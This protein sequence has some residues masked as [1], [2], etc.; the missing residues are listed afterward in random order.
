M[1]G[2]PSDYVGAVLKARTQ[3]NKL[4]AD[5]L[6]ILRLEEERMVRA[7]LLDATRNPGPVTKARATSLIRSVK[8]HLG[9]YGLRMNQHTTTQIKKAIDLG[10]VGHVN[11]A[12]AVTPGLVSE[13]LFN[14]VPPQTLESLALRRGYGQSALFQTWRSTANGA[15]SSMDTWLFQQVGSGMKQATAVRGIATNL[16][17]GDSKRVSTLIQKLGQ[18]GRFRLKLPLGERQRLNALMK[19]TGPIAKTF[20]KDLKEARGLLRDARRIAV[21]EPNTAYFEADRMSAAESPLVAGVKWNLSGRHDAI[22]QVD[23]C[24]VFVSADYYKMGAG[25]FPAEV[26]PARP[27]PYCACWLESVMRPASEWGKPKPAYG[28]PTGVT[29]SKVK[30]L[31]EK[32]AKEQAKSGAKV[33]K[34]TKARVRRVRSKSNSGVGRSNVVQNGGGTIVP[35]PPKPP[36]KVITPPVDKLAG[37]S[38]L[39]TV[40]EEEWVSALSSMLHGGES[41][42]FVTK[43]GKLKASDM[44]ALPPSILKRTPVLTRLLDESGSRVKSLTQQWSKAQRKYVQNTG[45]SVETGASKAARKRAV[46]TMNRTREDIERIVAVQRDLAVR[47]GLDPE[48]YAQMPKVLTRTILELMEQAKGSPAA[49]KA[50]Q[51]ALDDVEALRQKIANLVKGRSVDQTT[52]DRHIAT[53]TKEAR[54][55]FEK[56]A[57]AKTATERN[58]Q[59]AKLTSAARRAQQRAEITPSTERAHF[60]LRK[61]PAPKGRERV[62]LVGRTGKGRFEGKYPDAVTG[63]DRVDGFIEEQGSR[64]F[65]W[66]NDHVAPYRPIAKKQPGSMQVGVKELKGKRKRAYSTGD[67]I[68]VSDQSNLATYIHEFGHQIENRFW[69]PNWQD[70]RTHDRGTRAARAFLQYRARSTTKTN[71]Y[72]GEKGWKDQFFE[73]YAGKDYGSQATEL[74]SMGIQALFENPVFFATVDQ[75]YFNFV[76]ILLRHGPRVAEDYV[77]KVLAKGNLPAWKGA[78]LG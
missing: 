51:E 15:I 43:L 6:R 36:V 5:M 78:H 31:M 4:T 37:G 33:S 27:H 75:E 67:A 47:V 2:N 45:L 40:R 48:K 61:A 73:H 28:K 39:E 54:E 49:M 50:V 8:T 19:G 62:K 69:N 9:Q 66:V 57:K 59:F 16:L 77:V 53:I 55:T 17:N 71:I 70:T 1:P 29:D 52:L 74:V 32:R 44:A 76:M 23:E 26:V 68:A 41:L 35:P 64:A 63:W 11:G 10:V 20:Q 46:T 42:H 3:A 18:R 7:I 38:V 13:T 34:I 12:A 22:G 21:T 72:R 25:V 30:A 24:D 60:I 58:A 65:A 14:Q 56:I